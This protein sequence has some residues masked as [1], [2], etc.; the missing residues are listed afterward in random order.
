MKCLKQCLLILASCMWIIPAAFAQDAELSKDHK[1]MG[2]AFAANAATMELLRLIEQKGDDADL[3]NVAAEL[4][5]QHTRVEQELRALSA[6]RGF[7]EDREQMEKAMEKIEKWREKP[8]GQEWDADAAEELKDMYKDGM[9]MFDDE[10]N[11]VS[12]PEVKNMMT[13]L[14]EN[15]RQYLATV[16]RLKEQT[17]K[18]WKK[19][20]EKPWKEEDSGEDLTE[21]EEKALKANKKAWKSIESE[22]AGD[23]ARSE[24]KHRKA[25]KKLRKME[26]K[27]TDGK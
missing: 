12:D 6:R 27:M 15:E 17:K 3:K 18:P 14:L 26:E 8:G 2:K 22:N 23:A 11:K 9:D 1:A 4:M 21:A 7:V 24:K 19:T 5:T 20:D 10:R 13:S 16:D 25:D